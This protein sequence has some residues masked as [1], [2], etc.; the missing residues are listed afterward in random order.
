MLDASKKASGIKSRQSK[1]QHKELNGSYS[2]EFDSRNSLKLD[3]F[4]EL[5]YQKFIKKDNNQNTSST[6]T[7]S[8]LDDED[9]KHHLI[10]ILENTG[11]ISNVLN[12]VLKASPSDAHEIENIMNWQDLGSIIFQIL[13]NLYLYEIT[14]KCTPAYISF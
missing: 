13:Q 12:Q 2:N 14:K 9:I 8:S 5:I 7:A 4:E 6:I 11:S 3:P 1:R 10:T